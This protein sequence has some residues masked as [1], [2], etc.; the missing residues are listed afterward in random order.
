MAYRGR[1]THRDAI[2][3]L[4]EQ[5]GGEVSVV[6]DDACAVTPK[7]RPV[8]SSEC[9]SGGA[10]NAIGSWIAYSASKSALNSMTL[11]S[12]ACSRHSFG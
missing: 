3:L 1:H 11:T 9:F 10:L 6:P 12:P 4:E 8:L 5:T 2:G 7:A